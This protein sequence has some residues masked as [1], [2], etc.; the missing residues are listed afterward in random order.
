MQNSLRISILIFFSFILTNH[1]MAS[2]VMGGDI[3]YKWLGAKKYEFTFNF[4]RD[5]RGI[6]IDTFNFRIFNKSNTVNLKLNASRV[7][8]TDITV[9][10][11]DTLQKYCTPTNKATTKNGVERHI[12]IAVVDL[13]S[14]SY[15]KFLDSQVC[16]I[17]VSADL[18]CR[19]GAIT[20]INPGNFFIQAMLNVCNSRYKNSSPVFVLPGIFNTNC[21]QPF[22]NNLGGTDI[23]DGDSI[24]YELIA[25]LKAFNTNES[26]TGNFTANIPMTPYCP[27]TPGTLTCLALPNALPPRGFYFSKRTGEIVFLASK[28]D[29]VGVIVLKI[30]E[31]RKVN[32]KWVHLGFVMRDIQVTVVTQSMNEAPKISSK[33]SV[34]FKLREETCFD[35]KSTD[36][37]VNPNST[38][39]FGDS[40]RIQ[41]VN[42]LPG[43]TMSYLD[44][45]SKNK[46]ARVCWT[47]PDS[48]LIQSK[49]LSKQILLIAES[50][51]NFCPQPALTRKSIILN[52]LPPKSFGYINILTYEDANRNKKFDQNE[53]TIQSDLLIQSANSSYN[54]R[55]NEDGEYKGILPVDT[56]KIGTQIHPYYE[57]SK[58]DTVLQIKDS[59][60]HFL[61][62]PRHLKRGVHG[63]VFHD[64][65]ANCIFDNGDLPISDIN[66]FTDSGKISAISDYEGKYYLNISKGKTYLIQTEKIDYAYQ[67]NCPTGNSYTINYSKDSIINDNNFSLTD[68]PE[69][70]NLKTNFSLQTLRRG[71]T[72]KLSIRCENIGNKTGAKIHL[73]LP[74]PNGIQI[75][76][77]TTQLSGGNDTLSF[78]ID[79]LKSK[80]L[81]LKKLSLIVDPNIYSSGDLVCFKIWMDSIN[82]AKDS[83]K[84]NN[85]YALCT[86]VSAPYDPNNKVSHSEFITPLDKTID[87]NI[88]FQ[89]TG[90][91]TAFRVVVTDTI[92][93]SH[94][95]LTKFELNWSDAACST[96]IAG[97]VIYFVF[98]NIN[99][100]HQSLSGDKSISGFGFRLGLKNITNTT[101]I[102]ENRAGIY[103]DFESEI[104]TK[105]AFTIIKSPVEI[106]QSTDTVMCQN[107]FKTIEFKANVPINNGDI[108]SLEISDGNGSF[109]NPLII[110][111]KPANMISDTFKFILNSNY[112][113]ERSLRINLLKPN[114]QGIN[115][116]GIIRFKIDSL[117]YYQMSSNILNGNIC[118]YDTLKLS[119]NGPENQYKLVKNNDYSTS[120]SA[121]NYLI[122]KVNT[123]DNFKVIVKRKNSTCSDT[124]NLS[125]NILPKPQIN[126]EIL[127]PKAKYCIKDSIYLKAKG[128]EKYIFY[129]NSTALNSLDTSSNNLVTTLANNNLYVFG[130]AVN[131][132][133][134]FSDTISITGEP[135]PNKPIISENKNVLSIPYYPFISWYKN[136]SKLID[137]GNSIQQAQSGIYKVIVGNI[138]NCFIASDEFNHIYEPVSVNS[139]IISDSL[140]I[141]PNPAE[142]VITIINSSSTNDQIYLY[143]LQG[144]LLISIKLDADKIDIDIK[145]LK[146]GIYFIKNGN[147]YYK[148]IKT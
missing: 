123:N 125:L 106:I 20:T 147:S 73:F 37:K 47:P 94:L 32:G 113:G 26:Y 138:N 2:H 87:Y 67:I 48:I 24:T 16:E 144:Q 52:I 108:Y 54:I 39:N 136:G 91:D 4:Y 57:N 63:R 43:M 8:I 35:I 142:D 33:T 64:N 41:L 120:F 21:N 146:A 12:F 145:N 19:N 89:N 143:D 60:Y 11:N 74:V 71:D 99:L 27:P 128:G 55:T 70:F 42:P 111:T 95:D 31:Y 1:S 81:F 110:R 139:E 28:C 90:N 135:L 30:N 59:A 112:Y 84:G 127:N 116:T 140:I 25:P 51:D 78:Y 10:C 66:V 49:N 76:D 18:C 46:T 114:G 88:Y 44:T 6:P 22:R 62:F 122:S 14:Q 72:S 98:D 107:R 109:L 148:I 124:S 83:V 118:E 102:I 131:A 23:Y 34:N 103:F 36:Y 96:Y 117:P 45:N 97:D 65:N 38:S 105:S 17:Y 126:I 115:T 58:L 61:E 5:C 86:R 69:Y 77:G 56:F 129:N 79:S 85:Q 9:L 104:I 134:N 93:N 137:T 92:K 133:S 121:D 141:Y 15:K 53:N 29:E 40:T 100:P 7:S 130:K 75:F 80:V 68:N 3:S 132:C 13:E 119:F 50:Y 101:N 82:L